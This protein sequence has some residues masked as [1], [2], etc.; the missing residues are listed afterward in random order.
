MESNEWPLVAFTIIAQL[1]LG[2]LL[3]CL[4]LNGY[5][6]SK[7][8]LEIAGDVARHVV[9]IAAPLLILS[10]FFSLL[11]LGTPGK[12]VKTVRNLGSS[13]LSREAFLMGVVTAVVC[14]L[15]G[16]NMFAEIPLGVVKL[17][18]WAAAVL[19][20]VLVFCMSKIYLLRTV[21]VWNRFTT[22]VAF[23]TTT[24]LL[25]VLVY[26]AV[27]VFT[28]HRAQD[29]WLVEILPM[30]TLPALFLVG[31]EFL[32]IPLGLFMG[33][34]GNALSQGMVSVRKDH[35]L[36]FVLR[37]V[38]VY[39]AMGL[40]FAGLFT[41]SVL[42]VYPAFLLVLAAEVIGRFFFYATYARVGI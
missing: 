2:M 29:S 17:L 23:F 33:G 37:L 42:M 10:L 12:A 1:A 14:L 21:P 6:V 19:S 26:A 13:W 9:F 30:V 36:A 34:T 22:P 20:L 18:E 8:G 27:C 41:N 16:L 4:G 35:R 31:I 11:H 5:L 3:V 7:A 28:S 24:L 25:G 38:F 40:M 39:A 32:I 15:A